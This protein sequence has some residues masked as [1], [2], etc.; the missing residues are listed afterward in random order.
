MLREMSPASELVLPFQESREGLH[1]VS[2]TSGIEAERSL[3]YFC[4][5]LKSLAA[6]AHLK[7]SWLLPAQREQLD[8]HSVFSPL[9]SPVKIYCES[10]PRNLPFLVGLPS[11]PTSRWLDPSHQ[12]SACLDMKFLRFSRGGS[13]VCKNRFARSWTKAGKA[14]NEN[15]GMLF[16]ALCPYLCP[17]EDRAVLQTQCVQ[18]L[19]WHS[20][21]GLQ[22]PQT[23]HPCCLVPDTPRH[24]LL[25]FRLGLHVY[26]SKMCTLGSC[27]HFA[28]QK[29]TSRFLDWYP[30]A[31]PSTYVSYKG[32]EIT[33]SDSRSICQV[34]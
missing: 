18:P 13:D 26:H 23:Y 5:P 20:R 4:S 16:S 9:H 8:V 28:I 7:A 30:E 27:M 21:Q 31:E 14:E 2:V 25:L 32:M 3:K 33:S 34:I 6:P 1:R 10:L 29:A 19:L 12:I 17:K 11:F 24:R 15:L 22:S